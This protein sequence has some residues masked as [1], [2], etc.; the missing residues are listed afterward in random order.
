MT[1]IAPTTASMPGCSMQGP[2]PTTSPAATP[3]LASVIQQLS[4]VTT[5]LTALVQAL[6][7]Q[8]QL[9]APTTDPL[10]GFVAT[11]D[12]AERASLG[13]ALGS[14]GA[15]SVGAQLLGAVR[16]R[17]VKLDILNDAAFDAQ[18]GGTHQGAAA[19]A[20]DDPTGRKVLIRSSSMAA[21]P[22]K[23]L[24]TLAHELTHVAQYQ[25]GEGIQT[26]A[27]G[28]GAAANGLT[29]AQLTT[30]RSLMLESGAETVASSIDAERSDPASFR[31]KA[32]KNI[33]A[34]EAAEWKLVNESGYNPQGLALTQ[35]VSP[36][37]L[38][39][40]HAAVG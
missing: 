11:G 35:F 20:V 38:A 31:A 3:D 40:V 22:A 39:L 14:I 29:A 34:V 19:V 13:T 28:I 33:P 2:A 26:Y 24:H 17:N 36:T 25:S 32:A 8:Q 10:A 16:N 21:D 27:A 15:T 9:A 4:A 37:A 18:T 5:Q 6:Q 23:L 1:A 12:A 30:G 7:G